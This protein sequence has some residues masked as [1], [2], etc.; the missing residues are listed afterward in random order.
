LLKAEVLASVVLSGCREEINKDRLWKAIE[1]EID[2]MRETGTLP[3]SETD[4]IE[5]ITR[6]FTSRKKQIFLMDYENIEPE[7]TGLEYFDK[8]ET[9]AQVKTETDFTAKKNPKIGVANS[10]AAICT[11]YFVTRKHI[12]D[13]IQSRRDLDKR[14]QDAGE[15]PLA[16]SCLVM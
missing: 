5:E 3:D 9:L 13:V 2:E 1:E 14:R 6:R 4:V 10:S 15:K 7:F 12:K 16:P 8:L 11:S